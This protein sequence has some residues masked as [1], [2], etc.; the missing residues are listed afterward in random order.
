M[1]DFTDYNIGP[2]IINYQN[3]QYYINVHPKE[4]ENFD[5]PMKCINLKQKIYNIT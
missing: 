4:N 5:I 1:K 3:N 2:R